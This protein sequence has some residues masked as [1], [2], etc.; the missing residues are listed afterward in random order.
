MKTIILFVKFKGKSTMEKPI[1]MQF[2]IQMIKT[3]YL[4]M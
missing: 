2:A 4:I 3:G 1:N